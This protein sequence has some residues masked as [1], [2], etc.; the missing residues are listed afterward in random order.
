HY[1]SINEV[2]LGRGPR[3]A[4][5]QNGEANLTVAREAI[6]QTLNIIDQ[7]DESDLHALRAMRAELRST[8]RAIGTERVAD[9]LAAVPGSLPSLAQELG[10]GEPVVHIE[11]NGC[12][13]RSEAAGTVKNVFMHLLR[14]SLDH[15]IEAP[16]QRLAAGKE[17]AGRIDIVVSVRSGA[18]QMT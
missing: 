9:A 11:D 4:G 12:R 17:E 10:K 5:A 3:A 16:A 13:L 14:N 7:T 6:E 18:L 2:S 8:L 1:S 15:G